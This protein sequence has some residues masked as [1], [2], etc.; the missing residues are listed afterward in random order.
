MQTVGFLIE[1][2]TAVRWHCV[3]CEKSGLANLEAIRKAKGP[4]YDLTDRTPRC[5]QPDCLGRVWFS[6]RLGSWMRKLLTADGE[7]RL[8]AHGDWVFAERMRLR[9]ES[10]KGPAAARGR[11]A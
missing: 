1:S 4:E 3:T 10:K 6:V 2:G 9:S 7:A 5:Q 8:E 11:G